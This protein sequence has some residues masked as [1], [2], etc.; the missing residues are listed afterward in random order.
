MKNYHGIIVDASQNDK[1]IFNKFKILGKK[2]SS[3]EEW[4]LYRIEVKPKELKKII[5]LLQQNMLNKKF[6]FHFYRDKELFVIF[7]NKIF[8]ITPSKSTWDDAIK[9]GKSIKIPS[10]QLDFFPCTV[11]EETY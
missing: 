10:K 9:Y 11:E 5:K 2:K 7:K 4:I 3:S 6:Y 1:S 8:K